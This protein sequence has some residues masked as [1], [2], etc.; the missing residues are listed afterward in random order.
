MR[1]DNDESTATLA[2]T[3]GRPTDARV[4]GAQLFLLPIETRTPLKFG[5]ETLTSVTCARVRIELE[6]RDGSRRAVGWGETPLSVQWVWPSA[7]P[8]ADRLAALEGFCRRLVEAWVAFDRVGHPLELGVA[9]QAEVLEPLARDTSSSS[10][11]EPL[12][13][14]AALV[15]CSPFDLALYDGF[16]RLHDRPAFACLAEDLLSTDLAPL[17]GDAALAGKRPDSLLREKRLDAI[18]AWHLVGGLDPLDESDL[19]GDEPGDGYPVLLSDWIKRDGLRCLK[20]KLRGDDLEWDHE[21]MVRVGRI[22]LPLGVED[23]TADFNCTVTDPA[24]VVEAL[25]RLAADAP[26]VHERLLY[27]EQP[28][29]YDLD[30]WPIDVSEVSRRKPLL[31][32]ES[33]HDWR[34]VRRG[35]E[36]GWTGVALKTCK[37][38]SGAL[39]SLAYARRHGMAVMVQDLTNPMLAQVPHTLLAAHI[40]TLRGV[41][42]NAMQFYP[43]A[44]AP[45]A[46][47]HP[48]LYRRRD[49][50]LDLSTL[51]G[52]GFGYAGAEEARQLPEPV[53]ATERTA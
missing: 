13:L 12:P 51:R 32:D 19:T 15:C 6:T 34:F 26:D 39:L 28:F 33:A 21:R 35:R 29:P 27:V 47:I 23:F 14:L 53:A 31:L 41:E 2:S 46:A 11:A 10:A 20:V 38:L 44:S 24:Y 37:T 5:T 49:G 50:R 22:G 42:S 17:L 8:Y 9:F 40:D 52:S 1:A 3:D 43:D 4:V 30:R 25:D 48:G 7:E 16:G 36:L 45:E 18:D